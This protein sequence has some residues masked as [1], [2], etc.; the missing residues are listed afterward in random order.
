MRTQFV[1][2]SRSFDATWPW[3]LCRFVAVS[4]APTW[5]G[6]VSLAACMNWWIGGPQLTTAGQNGFY[7]IGAVAGLVTGIIAAIAMTTYYDSREP[8]SL[9]WLVFLGSSAF[10]GLLAGGILSCLISISNFPFPHNW[11]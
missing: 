10:A 7:W 1:N 5:I 9:M 6:G 3:L 11:F 8:R 2:D 4:F